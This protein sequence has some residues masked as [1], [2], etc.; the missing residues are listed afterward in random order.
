[1]ARVLVVEDD[2]GIAEPLVRALQREGYDTVRVATG[3]A[4]TDVVRDGHVDLVVLDLGLPDVD[5]VS[6]CRALRSADESL[7]ILVLTARSEELDVIIGLDAGADD[8]VTKPFRLGELLA[9]V[10][11]RVRTR[12]NAMLHVQNVEIDVA[13][14]RA[15]HAGEE[16]ELT[17]KEFDLLSLLARNAGVVVTREEIMNTVWDE[18]WTGSTR[19]L[20]V[21]ISWLRRKLGDD[22]AA[23]RYVSTVRGTGFRFETG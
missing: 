17:A 11:A 14:R 12:T 15:W 1:M 6:V 10:R 8:Y 2:D 21:H 5:G 18:H 13:A 7:P 3:G 22:A 20:D 23:S 19:T 16:L 4:A 9:R